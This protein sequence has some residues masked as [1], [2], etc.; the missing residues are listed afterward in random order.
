VTWYDRLLCR[1][2][3]FLRRRISPR[4]SLEHQR[5]Y[6]LEMIT[7]RRP[8]GQASVAICFGTPDEKRILASVTCDVDQLENFREQL[9]RVISLIRAYEQPEA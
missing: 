9:H 3:R 1:L 4:F 7:P 6:W 8:N 5:V 2:V